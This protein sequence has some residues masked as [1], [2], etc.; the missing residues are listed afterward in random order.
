MTDIHDLTS[1]KAARA[2]TVIAE[3]LDIPDDLIDS[4]CADAE[5]VADCG[6]AVAALDDAG[7]LALFRGRVE[8]L[9]LAEPDGAAVAAEAVAQAGGSRGEVAQLVLQLAD[10][11]PLLLVIAAAKLK[12]RVRGRNFAA[13][14]ELSLKAD[15]PRLRKAIRDLLP[16]DR[17]G[18]AGED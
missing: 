3:R 18:D 14:A 2:L 9:A 10:Y 17:A 15:L 12:I 1:G 8:D 6:R 7:K 13:D 11:L 4:V 5:F 16:S